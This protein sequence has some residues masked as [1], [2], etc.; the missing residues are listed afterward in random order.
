LLNALIITSLQGKKDT[1]LKITT[2]KHRRCQGITA[3]GHGSTKGLISVCDTTYVCLI[4]QL[5]GLY[6][7]ERSL[8]SLKI[9]GAN[10]CAIKLKRDTQILFILIVIYE[11]D[12]RKI[13]YFLSIQYNNKNYQ[14]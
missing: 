14:I 4:G 10:Q 13:G 8:L 11:I 9:R 3:P 5:I 6:N 2:F 7:L 12:S 1:E